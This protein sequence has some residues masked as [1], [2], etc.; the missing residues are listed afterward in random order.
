MCC[1]YIV[2]NNLYLLK[3]LFIIIIV[4]ENGGVSRIIKRYNQTC[5]STFEIN[6]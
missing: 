4:G 6:G 1:T 3:L 2:N 5:V